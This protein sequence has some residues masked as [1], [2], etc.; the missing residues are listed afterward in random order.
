MFT[1]I[2]QWGWVL[3]FL[4]AAELPLAAG[5]F[6]V[7][8]LV[9]MFV[10]AL[11]NRYLRSRGDGDDED[12]AGGGASAAAARAAVGESTGLGAV[13]P[14]LLATYIAAVP[15][16]GAR[17][18]ILFGFLLLINLGLFAISLARR[19]RRPCIWSARPPRSWSSRS[20]WGCPTATRPGRSSSPSSLCSRCSI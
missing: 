1:T 19:D 20:G 11:G 13:L 5:I 17:Y 8:P 15:R 2:Y 14:L 16:Y 10:V 3:K 18:G 12:D 9:T 4:S 7:F 6:L